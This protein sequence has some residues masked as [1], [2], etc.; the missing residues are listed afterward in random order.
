[1]NGPTCSSRQLGRAPDHQQRPLGVG[2][3]TLRIWDG[4]SFAGHHSIMLARNHASAAERTALLR[5]NRDVTERSGR[6]HRLRGHSIAQTTV[7]V[8]PPATPSAVEVAPR[9]T[10]LVP[11]GSVVGVVGPP[12]KR[13]QV[14]LA[15]KVVLV[16]HHDRVLLFCGGD[17]ATSD[18][19]TWWFPPGGGL[20][21]GE[22]TE[23]AARREV[24][25]ET[26]LELHDVGPIVSTA[27][28]SSH[29]TARRS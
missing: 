26:G 4:P 23:Q 5:P 6:R 25:E 2:R 11:S 22:T 12:S 3:R 9:R 7:S 16:D 20:E 1:M 14:R 15:A 27:L 29:S 18:D 17:P 21:P 13:A 24:L 8:R 10:R 19:E 28:R